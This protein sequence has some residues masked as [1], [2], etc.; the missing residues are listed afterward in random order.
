M[1]AR[2]KGTQCRTQSLNSTMGTFDGSHQVC[3]IFD[4]NAN[5]SFAPPPHLLVTKNLLVLSIPILHTTSFQRGEAL[6]HH[7]P[8]HEKAFNHHQPTRGKAFN[9][10]HPHGHGKAF[11]HHQPTHGNRRS[12]AITP[13]LRNLTDKLWKSALKAQ[14]NPASTLSSL[15]LSSAS[16]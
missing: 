12:I 10:H 4:G 3:R 14:S 2:V 6:N 16:D 7:H 11:N 15:R 1:V 5:P 13:V 8:Q 9:R